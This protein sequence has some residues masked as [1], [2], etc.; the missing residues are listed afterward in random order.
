MRFGSDPIVAEIL[1]FIEAPSKRG[2]IRR[3]TRAVE[4]DDAA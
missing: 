2:L 4:T 3:D 1:G